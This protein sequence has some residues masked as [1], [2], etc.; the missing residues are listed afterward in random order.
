MSYRWS[1]NARENKWVFKRDLSR[2]KY[3]WSGFACS[4]SPRIHAFPV[5]CIGPLLQQLQP[6]LWCITHIYTFLK[7][8]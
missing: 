2:K 3:D 1:A 6:I 8:I 4:Q 5:T 7:I